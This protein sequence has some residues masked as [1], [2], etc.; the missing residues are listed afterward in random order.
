VSESSGFHDAPDRGPLPQHPDGARPHDIPI[1]SDTVDVPSPN[2]IK[3]H[4]AQDAG[5]TVQFYQVEMPKN[6]WQA[7]QKHLI[8]PNLAVL[9][10]RK[11]GRWATIIIQQD[12][13]TRTRVM[14]TIA[15]HK[16]GPPG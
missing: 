1:L 4:T 14:I 3:Y 12:E 10:Y 2:L 9:S 5:D 11:D 8:R 7:S 15:R 13:A 6:D 16:A